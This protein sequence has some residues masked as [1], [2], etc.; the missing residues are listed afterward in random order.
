MG[1]LRNARSIGCREGNHVNNGWWNSGRKAD[2]AFAI[3][4]EARRVGLSLRGQRFSSVGR[5]GG[6][7]PRNGEAA[8]RR[9]WREG[10]PKKKA[11]E[12]DGLLVSRRIGIRTRITAAQPGHTSG[13]CEMDAREE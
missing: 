8:G 12:K 7:E 11:D 1:G 6:R 10:T 3:P 9:N 4:L 5:S 13:A 2:D